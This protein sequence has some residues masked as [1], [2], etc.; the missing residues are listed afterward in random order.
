MVVGTHR[1][2]CCVLQRCIDHA[3]GFQRAHLI[4]QITDNAF[5]L[6]Q[7]PFG[8]YVLQ[9]IVDLQESCFTDP[10]CYTFQGQIPQLSKQKFSSNVIEKCLRGAQHSVT[11]MMIDEMLNTNEL[12]KMLR[13]S[14]ANYVVQTAMDYGD[15]EIK[16][17]LVDSI[18]PLL[19]AVR[20]TPHGRRI[21]SKISAIDG[22]GRFSGTGTPTDRS[23]G[24]T[25]LGLQMTSASMTN[26]Q[27]APVNGFGNFAPPTRGIYPQF[28]QPQAQQAFGNPS[29]Y[30][31]FGA[32]QQQTN[33]QQPPSFS[34]VPQVNGGFF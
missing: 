25:P 24:Q 10:L 7:D 1:H 20:T 21:Q 28:P 17:R 12:E 19:P 8:N 27:P 30:M 9:Y 34:R 6:V 29:P 13:D 2:G 14:Y 31:Q 15:P 22:Q 33:V 18:R 4:A 16:G 32:E 11:R 23:G 26:G 5:H 3:T